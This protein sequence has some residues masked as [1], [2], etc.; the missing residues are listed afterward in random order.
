MVL[1]KFTEYEEEIRIRCRMLH[2]DNNPITVPVTR[3]IQQLADWEVVDGCYLVNKTDPGK[4]P[5]EYMA[6]LYELVSSQQFIDRPDIIRTKG[7]DQERLYNLLLDEVKDED[8]IESARKALIQCGDKLL[9]NL[10]A[11]DSKDNMKRASMCNDVG[12]A[13]AAVNKWINKHFGDEQPEETYSLCWT[14]ASIVD[15]YEIANKYPGWFVSSEV[16]L[17]NRD[18]PAMSPYSTKGPLY[19]LYYT[20]HGIE[21]GMLEV[22]CRTQEKLINDL[23]QQ[24]RHSTTR[25]DAWMTIVLSCT[26]MERTVKTDS[27]LTDEGRQDKLY[28]IAWALNAANRWIE[29]NMV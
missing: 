27:N 19:D 26:E 20:E 23:L 16:C 15:I 3:F 10:D 13:C 4:S 1:S 2:D 29:M 8:D 21:A 9:L 6:P 28:D 22:R 18:D 17:I 14:P 12:W 25:E 24:I 5:Y 11:L 7:T